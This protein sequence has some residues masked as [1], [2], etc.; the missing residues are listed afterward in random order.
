MKVQLN[1]LPASTQAELT[2]QVTAWNS[3]LFEA[4]SHYAERAFGLG[5]ALGILPGLV[6]L[7]V[8]WVTGIVNLILGLMLVLVGGLALTGIAG[9]LAYQ[10]RG[11]AIRRVFQETVAGEIAHYLANQPMDRLEFDRR[12]FLILPDDAPLRAFLEPSLPEDT[13]EVDDSIQPP[14]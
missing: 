11:N 13:Q 5:C 9:L 4:G 6:I 1:D 3:R 2:Q 14:V 12:A 8:L 7:L 10:A